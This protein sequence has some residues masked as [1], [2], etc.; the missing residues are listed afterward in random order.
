MGSGRGMGGLSVGPV[1]LPAILHP[2]HPPAPPVHVQQQQPG[3]DRE[4]R[5]KESQWICLSYIYM[6]M[7]VHLCISICM[8][9]CI[10]IC[11]NK[12]KG[13][14]IYIYVYLYTYT[15]VSVCILL[16]THRLL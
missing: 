2:A 15:H 5:E 16:R 4:C 14:Y 1:L 3:R 10:S 7:Y 13:I 12:C 9:I 6:Y 8:N 11:M